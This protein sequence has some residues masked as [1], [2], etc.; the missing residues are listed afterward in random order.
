MAAFTPAQQ[1]LH[2]ALTGVDS[3]LLLIVRQVI[4][5]GLTP[6]ADGKTDP[7]D[8]GAPVGTPGWAKIEDA[9]YAFDQAASGDDTT[10]MRAAL[11]VVN[12]VLGA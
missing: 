11:D 6:R 3:E 8:F 1:D 2:D 7:E 10:D 5:A 12:E 9:V 4:E